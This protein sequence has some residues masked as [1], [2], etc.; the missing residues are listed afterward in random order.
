MFGLSNI[1]LLAS[2]KKVNGFN[3]SI[4]EQASRL[5]VD[6]FIPHE[7]KIKFI[8]LLYFFNLNVMFAYVSEEGIVKQDAPTAIPYAL[9]MEINNAL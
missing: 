5:D 6:T 9:A 4:K 7:N 1:T 2:E 8:N 3:Q